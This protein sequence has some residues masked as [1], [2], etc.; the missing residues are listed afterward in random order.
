M[1][2]LCVGDFAVFPAASTFNT[3]SFAA[4]VSSGIGLYTPPPEVFTSLPGC[5]LSHSEIC[6]ERTISVV[7]CNQW[8]CIRVRGPA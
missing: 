8:H 3:K 2:C 6:V 1:H 7:A 4:F 5:L